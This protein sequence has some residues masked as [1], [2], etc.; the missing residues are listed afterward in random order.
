M[1]MN[2]FSNPLGISENVKSLLLIGVWVPLG[3]T[4]FYIKRLKKETT[5]EVESKETESETRKTQSKAR[6]SFIATWICGVVFSLAAPFWLP[7][8]GT[9]LGKRGDLLVGV[10]TAGMVSVI[11]G[12][13]WKKMPNQR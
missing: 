12:L 5:V 4:F 13:R 2:V 10:L 7:T 11:F 1:L 6:N 9:I 8:T 3:L